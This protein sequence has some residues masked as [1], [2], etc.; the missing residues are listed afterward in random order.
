MTISRVRLSS[1]KEEAWFDPHF[2]PLETSMEGARGEPF[3]TIINLLF[4]ALMS[5]RRWFR[6]RDALDSRNLEP[7]VAE[8]FASIVLSAGA[9]P[10]LLLTASVAP[11]SKASVD[12]YH[13]RVKGE[14]YTVRE[15]PKTAR[16]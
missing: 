8:H 7:E 11:P 13:Q 12:I 2:T 16:T 4:K 6:T 5:I 10:L 1:L 14:I 9:M 15:G 3:C